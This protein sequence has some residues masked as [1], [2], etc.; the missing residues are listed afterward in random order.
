MNIRRIIKEELLKEVGGYDDKNI[1]NIHAGATMGSLTEIYSDLTNTLQGLANAIMDGHSKDDFVSYLKETSEEIGVLLDTIKIIVG[2]FTEDD[3]IR[4]AKNFTKSLNSFKRKID[5]LYNFSDAMGSDT[6]F[7]EKVKDLLIDLVPSLQKYGEQL[8]ITNKV[9]KDRLK[10]H[11][12][13]SF[14]SGFS[15]N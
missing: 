1:M 9:F 7:V 2:E 15:Y 14:G 10:G 13:G 4:K 3:L 5:V 11:T 12:R 6:E 8:Q